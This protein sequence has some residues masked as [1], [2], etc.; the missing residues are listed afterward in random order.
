VTDVQYSTVPS[1]PIEVRDGENSDLAGSSLVMITA[2]VNEKGG[3]AMLVNRDPRPLLQFRP[4]YLSS[5][6]FTAFM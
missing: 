1:P 6:Y 4:S 2:G 5:S 3:E